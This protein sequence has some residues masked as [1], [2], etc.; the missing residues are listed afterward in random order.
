MKELKTKYWAMPLIPEYDDED[1]EYI[2][3]TYEQLRSLPQEIQ[4]DIEIWLSHIIYKYWLE[5]RDIM[6]MT[7]YEIW[8]M[9]NDK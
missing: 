9:I 4:N 8:M 2:N 5:Y 6:W 1:I 7:K 3:K